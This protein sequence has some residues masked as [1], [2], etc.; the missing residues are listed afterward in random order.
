M[1][2][3]MIIRSDSMKIGEFAKTFKVSKET[4]RFYTD[5]KLLTPVR[6]GNWYDYNQNCQDDMETVL[7]LKK[8]DFTIDEI[9]KYFSYFRISTNHTITM[10]KEIIRLFEEKHRD[11]EDKINELSL[12]KLE[13]RKRTQALRDYDESDTTYEKPLGLPLE[14]IPLLRCPECGGNLS[15]ENGK[16][17]YNSILSGRL[18]C[19]CG[20]EAKIAEGIVVFEGA[21]SD[22]PFKQPF[23]GE[24]YKAL[25]ENDERLIDQDEMLPSGYISSLTAV[26]NWLGE[27]LAA[28]SPSGSVILDPM[29]HS[30][31]I[32]NRVIEKLQSRVNNFVYIALD[33]RFSL[34]HN[35]KKLLEKN[36][37]R[38]RALFLCGDYRKLP[39]AV[40]S[41]DYLYSTFGTQSY[42]IY[43]RE[44]PVTELLNYLKRGG[45]WYEVFFCCHSK[46]E[47]KKEFLD[48]EHMLNASRIR[49]SLAEFSTS[50]FREIEKLNQ[51]G[52]LT[53]YFKPEAKLS[54]YA[55]IGTK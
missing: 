48:I 12:A 52:E 27:K 5:K 30:G 45:K 43:K 10:K 39:V 21:Q 38:P 37:S 31:I 51:K 54:M 35:F 8:M 24:K 47:I 13:I 42:T 15:V 3:F 23:E 44:S 1:E 55:F 6:V 19:D 20:Y 26:T 33:P 14:L 18:V 49:D 9:L 32:S 28:E 2:K 16:V 4:I 40:N 25:F 50:S 34:I 29:T 53:F 7:L 17:N 46:R 11:I 36:R 22:D 41:V